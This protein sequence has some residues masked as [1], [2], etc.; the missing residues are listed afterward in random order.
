MD[1]VE[2]YQID[3]GNGK[4]VA[5]KKPVLS[6]F[7]S[8]SWGVSADSRDAV[9]FLYMPNLRR[10]EGTGV[11]R[12]VHS[13]NILYLGMIDNDTGELCSDVVIYCKPETY[14]DIKV[15][16]CGDT[17]IKA[18]MDKTI[19][20]YGIRYA[21]AFALVPRSAYFSNA[22]KMY[23]AASGLEMSRYSIKN[24]MVVTYDDICL[25]NKYN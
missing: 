24:R 14:R 4:V 10:S 3:K 5:Y 16:A 22:D 9:K 8:D 20:G 1:T 11:K 21:H 19:K 15:L 25:T 13:K 7:I 12:A 2:F 6:H 17:Y 18:R 23:S